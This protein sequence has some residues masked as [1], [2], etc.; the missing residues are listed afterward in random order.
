M[1]IAVINLER[2][3]ERRARMLGLLAE[4]GVTARFFAAVDGRAGPHPLFDR[5]DQHAAE[6]R[7][8][9]RLNPGE[10]GCYAS[11]YLLWQEAV[12]TGR[13]V[14]ILE[15][16]I[17][18]APDFA[19]AVALVARHIDDAALIRLSAHKDRP[20]LPVADLDGRHRLVRFPLGPHGT[21]GYAV[22]PRGAA[23][24]LGAADM[25]FEPVDCH[26]DRFWTH[27]V[28]C[29]AL[30]PFPVT[31]A[32]PEAEDSDIR[33]GLDKVRKSRR[34]RWRRFLYRARDD[35][36]RYLSNLRLASRSPIRG[37]DNPRADKA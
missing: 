16:D 26:L 19:A 17:D 29:Y 31:H 34:Y 33:A 30:H 9:F 24:L 23:K 25:W 3:A 10:I 13:S 21:T 27:G 28:P 7:R 2:S 4:A 22:S 37:R 6:V 18:I 32:S 15:D 5:V 8:G 20:F 36:L 12:A 35:L 11:H 1:D 14:L